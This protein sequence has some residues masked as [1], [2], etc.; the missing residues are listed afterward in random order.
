[1]ANEDD[2]KKGG[3][4]CP[5][6]K[7]ECIEGKCPSMGELKCSLWSQIFTF[8]TRFNI[9]VAKGMCVF[10]AQLLIL[11][12]PRPEAQKMPLSQLRIK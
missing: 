5:W 11:G 12:T 7:E 3:V 8:D 6:M 2:G 9:P 1:M 4:F 10:P